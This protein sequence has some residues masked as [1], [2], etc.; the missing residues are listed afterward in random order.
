VPAGFDRVARI[1]FSQPGKMTLVAASGATVTV[2][3][4]HAWVMGGKR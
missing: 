4:D 2:P 3:L 1:D